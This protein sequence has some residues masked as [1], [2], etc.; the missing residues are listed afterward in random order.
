MKTTIIVLIALALTGIIA[1]DIPWLGDNH[2]A[3]TMEDGRDWSK[4]FYAKDHQIEWSDIIFTRIVNP[5]P[6]RCVLELT[7]INTGQTFTVRHRDVLSGDHYKVVLKTLTGE[8]IST[9]NLIIH[10]PS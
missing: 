2:I 6:Q 9:H 8:V 3:F 1:N 5:S 7:N 4:D 10:H